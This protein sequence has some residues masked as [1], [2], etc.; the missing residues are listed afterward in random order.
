MGN[1][2]PASGEEQEFVDVYSLLPALAGDEYTRTNAIRYMNLLIEMSRS[3]YIATDVRGAI[4]F[5]E[6]FSLS[7]YN[8]RSEQMADLVEIVK[9]NRASFDDG[10]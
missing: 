7:L 2:V 9:K 10:F 8:L 5:V 3:E 1:E 4:G 6:R